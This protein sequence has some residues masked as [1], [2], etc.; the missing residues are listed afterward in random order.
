MCYTKFPNYGKRQL[1]QHDFNEL[2]EIICKLSPTCI[3]DKIRIRCPLCGD[4]DSYFTV[5]GEFVYD[6]NK[7]I[8]KC[9][10]EHNGVVCGSYTIKQFTR[11]VRKL[12]SDWDK[13][14]IGSKI[15]LHKYSHILKW[16]HLLK[17]DFSKITI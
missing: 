3:I 4:N 6:N 8:Y 2:Y 13:L 12:H 14:S 17:M 9:S 7:W 11:K 10:N 1:S 5:C 15:D 16:N